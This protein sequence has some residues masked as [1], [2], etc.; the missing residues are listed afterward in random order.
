V[1][2]TVLLRCTEETRLPLDCVVDYLA[3]DSRVNCDLEI[4]VSSLFYD[5]LGTRLY[6]PISVSIFT[7]LST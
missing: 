5:V 7:F 2:L 4:G 3:L 1:A 6:K